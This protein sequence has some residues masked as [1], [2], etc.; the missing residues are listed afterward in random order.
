MRAL[1][2]A[3]PPRAEPLKRRP[4]VE[5]FSAGAIGGHVLGLTDG[6]LDGQGLYAALS[7]GGHTLLAGAIAGAAGATA[8]RLAGGAGALRK[9]L[10]LGCAGALFFGVASVLVHASPEAQSELFRGGA[11]NSV[12]AGFVGGAFGG[13][14]SNKMATPPLR[15]A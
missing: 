13:W 14:L 4:I 3:Q 9:P 2:S 7:L 10:T 11:V 1:T 8:H 5:W 6:L 12:I 15:H